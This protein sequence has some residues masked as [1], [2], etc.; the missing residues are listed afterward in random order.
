M[1]ILSK[2]LGVAY[3]L[4][5]V[6]A[7]AGLFRRKPVPNLEAEETRMVREMSYEEWRKLYERYKDK[8]QA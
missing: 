3:L 7:L 5:G 4:R 6:E 8:P 2:L 1:N